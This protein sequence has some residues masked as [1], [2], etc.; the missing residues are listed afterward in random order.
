MRPVTRHTRTRLTPLAAIAALAVLMM[1]AP[2]VSAQVPVPPL[3][4][5]PVV[6]AFA[7]TGLSMPY[8]Q[9][10]GTI[11]GYQQYIP[12]GSVVLTDNQYSC[13]APQFAACNIIYWPGFGQVLLATTLPA[14]AF[15][16]GTTVID[17][18][19]TGGGIITGVTS[20]SQGIP[21]PAGVPIPQWFNPSASGALPT[22]LRLPV[23]N[24]LLRS[25]CQV[26]AGTLSGY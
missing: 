6:Q 22:G 13:I 20:A 23:C 24:S 14:A 5:P 8:T 1:A 4:G 12:A 18:I 26:N 7:A 19:T 10:A 11:G 3:G 21:V 16:A 17:F 25:G 2:R 9:G 15:A